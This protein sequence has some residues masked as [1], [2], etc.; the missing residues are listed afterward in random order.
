MVVAPSA[1]QDVG[2]RAAL[3][4][5]TL[6]DAA[7]AYE[8]AFEGGTEQITDAGEYRRAYGAIIDAS[9]RQ[10]EAV[11]NDARGA[12]RAGLDNIARRTLPGPTPPADPRNPETVLGELSGL[13]D[14][15]AQTAGIDPTFPATDPGTPDQLRSL[16]R[17]VAAAV[18]SWE[19][20]DR[21]GGL[22]QL[23]NADLVYLNPAAASVAAVSLA[24]LHEMERGALVE[25]PDAMRSDGDV[26]AAGTDLDADIDEAIAQI[27]Q[28]LELL[29]EG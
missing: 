21:A 7:T 17:A 8:T 14:Q 19:R 16:K 24:L 13:A 29:R 20:G 10:L 2:F 12:I 4:Y 15:V 9:T 22:A 28:E 26:V 3:L 1:R 5:E 6:I 18:E 27:E 25:L 23:S 11:P